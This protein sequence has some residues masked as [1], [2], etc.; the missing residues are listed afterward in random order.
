[1]HLT[2]LKAEL[3]GAVATLDLHYAELKAAA[4]ERLRRLFNPGDFL[5]SHNGLF[6]DRLDDLQGQLPLNGLRLFGHEH[7]PEAPWRVCS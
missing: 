5:G 4:R 6:T 3:E 7:D 2:T 1:V